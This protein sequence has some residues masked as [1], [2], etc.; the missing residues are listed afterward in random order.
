[1][2]SSSTQWKGK[3]VNVSKE[4]A[5]ELAEK[6]SEAAEAILKEAGLEPKR[7]SSRYGEWFEFKITAEQVELGPN[8]VNLTS[9]YAGAFAQLAGLFDLEGVELG[10]PFRANGK[11]YFFAG[12]APSRRKFPIYALDESGKGS[13]FTD[14][15]GIKASIRRG[16]VPA[17]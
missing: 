5:H 7:V 2:V 11:T 4:Q 12:I 1:V 10:Q 13:F 17:S 3:K 8:G 6:I 9:E 16:F 14:T 15:P